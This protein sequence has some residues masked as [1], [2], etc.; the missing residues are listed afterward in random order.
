MTVRK[1]PMRAIS[2]DRKGQK[3]AAANILSARTVL[4]ASCFAR[5]ETPASHPTSTSVDI[6]LT[7]SSDR[8]GQNRAAASILSAR[9]VL[10][11]S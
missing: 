11:A 6:Y 3:R 9:T 7:F 10:T 8:K 4:T 1:E 5:G 2:S